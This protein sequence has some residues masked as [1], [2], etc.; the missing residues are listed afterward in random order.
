MRALEQPEQLVATA[1]TVRPGQFPL[2]SM[3]SRAAAR[4][5]VFA[6]GRGQEF[7]P[8]LV[9]AIA[10]PLTWLQSYTRTRDSHWRESGASSPYRSFPDKPY[11]RPVVE[12]IQAEP[13]VFIEKSRDLMISWLC[14]GL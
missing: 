13:V 2:G 8:Q 5:M 9:K 6:K 11:F 4:A 12:T 10:D 7:T 1:Q 14:V 3:E